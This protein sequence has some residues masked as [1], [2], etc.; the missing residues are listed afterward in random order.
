MYFIQSILIGI[1]IAAS[2][3]PMAILCI[4]RTLVNGRHSGMAVGLGI[5]TGDLIYAIVAV[6]LYS[7]ISFFLS[8]YNGIIT[9]I[10]AMV[11]IILG[12][13]LLKKK[14]L[15]NSNT[16]NSKDFLSV[17]FLTLSNPMTILSFVAIA[18][19]LPKSNPVFTVI[20]IFLGSL[21]W[22]VFLVSVI[23]YTRH[24]FSEKV[25]KF[26]NTCSALLIIVFAL[27]RLLSLI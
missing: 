23:S 12:A 21:L 20:G 24:H 14:N 11:L 3:G 8:E 22:W 15:L 1:A 10:G 2:I 17:L 9:F 18:A 27:V 5:A 4:N 25:I 19:T 26:I 6:F 16:P 7:Y 13:S